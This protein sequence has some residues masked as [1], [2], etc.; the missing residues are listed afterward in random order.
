LRSVLKRMEF[1][2]SLKFEL[3]CIVL[4]LKLFYILR[5]RASLARTKS[6]ASTP[7]FKTR[8]LVSWRHPIWGRFL[9]EWSW[10][11]AQSSS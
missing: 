3:S 9:K 4:L 5:K 6:H 10:G 8:A 11:V 2:R 7:F 1:R